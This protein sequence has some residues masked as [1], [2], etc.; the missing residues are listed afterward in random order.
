VDDH[1][2]GADLHAVAHL[3]RPEQAEG[4]Q[5]LDRAAGG[6]RDFEDCFFPLQQA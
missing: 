3:D 1:R 2:V 6:N 5:P 4:L